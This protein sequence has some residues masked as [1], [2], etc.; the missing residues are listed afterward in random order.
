MLSAMGETQG[1][2]RYDHRLAPHIRPRSYSLRLS[3]DPDAEGFTGSVTICVELANPGNLIV[4]HALDLNI[5]SARIRQSGSEYTPSVGID[6][7]RQWITLRTDRHLEAG[8]AEL[9]FEYSGSYCENLV[10]LYTSEFQHDGTTRRLAVTQC[11]S[12]HAR[13]ILPCFDEPGFKAVF[14]V[15]LEV[16]RGLTAVSN[17]AEV[18]RSGHDGEDTGRYGKEMVTVRFAPTMVMSSYLLAIVVG[19]LEITEAADVPGREGPI[20]LR[21]VHP[22]GKGHLS[23][24]AIEVATEALR[25]FENY[26]DLAYP[27]DKVDLVAIPDFAFGAMENLGCITFREVLLLI[28][29]DTATP[30][31][32]QRVTDVVNHELAHMWFGNLVTMSWWNG[33]W[34]N[35][36]FAT[37]ME[38]SA[39]DA[40]RPEWDVWTTFGLT[41]A[42]A[43]D[44][45][46]LASTRPIEYEVVTAAD[47]EAMFDILTYEKGASVLRMLEQYL[48]VEKF[49]DGIRT[50]LRRHAHA[51]TETSDLWRDLEDSAGEPVQR[52]AEAWVF[53]G[54]HPLV[55][56]E[57]GASGQTLLIDQQPA[58]YRR[59]AAAERSPEPFP[60][61]M[62]IFTR[63]ASGNEE[64]YRFVLEEP[65]EISLGEPAELVRTN[66]GGSGFFRTL[67][68]RVERRAL[69]AGVE[70][71]LERFVVLD[72]TWFAV[73]AGHTEPGEIL[74]TISDLAALGEDDPSVWRRVTSVLGELN[75]LLTATQRTELERWISSMLGGLLD[76]FPP[77]ESCGRSA[78]V[79]ATLLV[80]LGV[81]GADPAAVALATA[82]FDGEHP[83]VHAAVAAAA[84]EVVAHDP[85]DERHAEIRRR[86]REASTPQDEQRH[87]GALVAT[88]RREQFQSGLGLC[89]G[90]IRSQDAPYVLRRALSNRDRGTEAWDFVVDHW[91]TLS[92]RLPSGSLPRMFEGIRG[93][94]DEWTSLAVER[95]LKSHPLPTGEQQVS[96]HVERM[97][98]SVA[99][100]VRI[101][102]WD[103][104]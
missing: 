69:L 39:T 93:F 59:P 33:I 49:R 43:F 4:L 36:A 56:V 12:T 64:T 101:Q 102:R 32:L 28:D 97:Q 84:L 54:G 78:E 95:F 52:L 6:I 60:V 21:V 100:A 58:L 35:E 48:G 23:D 51:N 3:V 81:T 72:D 19:P 38:I 11:E 2:D 30:I 57:P 42:A 14:E 103:F 62:R 90:D 46:A 88:I 22:P 45:D 67:L 34:L 1:T 40:F 87:L 16:P 80:T 13:R 82:V 41:R 70:C 75:R 29:P 104:Q 98:A 44:T 79:A 63:S 18:E 15:T 61:P 8:T 26:Y 96:Q 50:Y 77:L 71:P 37:F 31:E 7:E 55:S 9:C 65:T 10:G 94:T 85:D 25:F 86:W 76:S 83:D 27:G 20:P 73:M 99:A 5:H 92:E 89:L 66:P 68:P 24:F 47:S 91:E 17:G 74:A 53:R